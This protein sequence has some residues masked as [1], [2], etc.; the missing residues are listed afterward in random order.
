MPEYLVDY[1][2]KQQLGKANE[3]QEKFRR[4]GKEVDREKVAALAEAVSIYLAL[5]WNIVERLLF[6]IKR[7]IF[8]SFPSSPVRTNMIEAAIIFIYAFDSAYLHIL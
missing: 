4:N 6:I 1:I 3:L 5:L 7:L 2:A 8:I